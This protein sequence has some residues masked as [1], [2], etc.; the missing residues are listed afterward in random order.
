M[1]THAV[2]IFPIKVNLF[3]ISGLVISSRLVS[4]MIVKASET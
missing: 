2:R 3:I 4:W 1:K